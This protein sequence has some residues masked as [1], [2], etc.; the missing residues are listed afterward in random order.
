MEQKIFMQAEQYSAE[1][2]KNEIVR[3]ILRSNREKRV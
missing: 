1:I 3:G 2:P